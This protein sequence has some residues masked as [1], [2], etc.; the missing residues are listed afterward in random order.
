MMTDCLAGEKI[1]MTVLGVINFADQGSSSLL[2]L[3]IYNKFGEIFQ[4]KETC[5]YNN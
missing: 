4:L 5:F 1:V 3:L 2:I